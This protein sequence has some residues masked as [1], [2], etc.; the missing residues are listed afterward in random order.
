MASWSKRPRARM[1][2]TMRGTPRAPSG[3]IDELFSTAEAAEIVGISASRIRRF[4]EEDRL[5]T[6]VRGGKV[7]ALTLAD[8]EALRQLGRGK[9]GRP[10]Q[11]ERPSTRRASG[12]RRPS[13][14][15]ILSTDDVAGRTGLGH[16]T[17]KR[18][19][20]AGELPTARKI[21]GDWFFTAQDVTYLDRLYE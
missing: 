13:P 8:L 16:A 4:A 17:V 9:R 1:P 6:A 2:N 5:P 7:W 14:P 18:A 3:E 19:A 20:A 21:G 15:R 12:G 10:P 11:S